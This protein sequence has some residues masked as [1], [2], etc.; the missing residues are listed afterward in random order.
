MVNLLGLVVHSVRLVDL[1]NL[2]APEK[3]P[4]SRSY[5]WYPVHSEA[6][7]PAVTKEETSSLCSMPKANSLPDAAKVGHCVSSEGEHDV[8]VTLANSCDASVPVLLPNRASVVARNL[9]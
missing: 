5:L 6:I 2:D 3:D 9:R 4:Y 7:V 8:R 1:Y